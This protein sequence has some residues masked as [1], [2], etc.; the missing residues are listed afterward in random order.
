MF[1]GLRWIIIFNIYSI[2]CGLTTLTTSHN[3]E[4]LTIVRP[5]CRRDYNRMFS[6][7]DS[8]L[9]DYRPCDLNQAPRFNLIL[10]YCEDLMQDYAS[11]FI[12]PKLRK[13][14]ELIK[15]ANTS[16][17]TS[18]STNTNI[19]VGRCFKN[20]SYHS[21]KIQPNLNIYR[22]DLYGL[23]DLWVNGPNRH[24]E[25]IV[26]Y[27]DDLNQT[28]FYLME[29][30]SVP[31]K[32]DFLTRLDGEIRTKGPFAI[33][34]S[35][36]RGDR[37]D[38]IMPLIETS[39]KRHINGN[40]VYN[41]S[42]GLT[43]LVL[44]EIFSEENHTLNSYPYDYRI[45]QLVY[46][47][48][49]LYSFQLRNNSVWES[50]RGDSTVIGNYAA[51]NLHLD[52][53]G[54]ESIIHGA[55]LFDHFSEP[56]A[57]LVQDWGLEDYLDRFHSQLLLNIHP[58]SEIIYVVPYHK[59]PPKS[60]R[61]VK[62]NSLQNNRM[63][64]IRYEARDRPEYLQDQHQQ[65]Q[66]QQKSP[67]DYLDLCYHQPRTT[68][69]VMSTN[70]YM[71]LASPVYLLAEKTTGRPVINYLPLDSRSCREHSVCRNSL[72][73]AE[74]FAFTSTS[75]FNQTNRFVQNM[76]MIY[77]VSYLGSLNSPYSNS[78][79]KGFCNQWSK[80]FQVTNTGTNTATSTMTP[81]ITPSPKPSPSL[82]STLDRCVGQLSFSASVYLA[83]L[84]QINVS[85]LYYFSD[86]LARGNRESVV[87]VIQ[88]R[89][90]DPCLDHQAQTINQGDGHHH[91]RSRGRSG[92]VAETVAEII[93][94]VERQSEGYTS[95]MIH[96]LNIFNDPDECNR[97][98]YCWWRPKFNRCVQI[99]DQIDL[100][101]RTASSHQ[102]HHPPPHSTY[103]L[104]NQTT[105]HLQE[106]R[107][108][109]RSA[110]TLEQNL[111]DTDSNQ[112]NDDGD[113]D[114]V[115]L[116]QASETGRYPFTV[117]VDPCPSIERKECPPT[118]PWSITCTALLPSIV[119]GL[120][121]LGL[122]G[123]IGM[124]FLIKSAW[125]LGV[126]TSLH[127]FLN[128]P[129]FG[130]R[131]I[132]APPIHLNTMMTTYIPEI[133][134]VE[135]HEFHLPMMFTESAGHV[136]PGHGQFTIVPTMMPPP[137]YH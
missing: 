137:G 90:P 113:E 37:W 54:D 117:P 86:I 60:R 73:Y 128:T 96:C 9:N 62:I 19:Q 75:T 108:H 104:K 77:N 53:L 87:P 12:L 16:T 72:K 89:E 2:S 127:N 66:Q 88:S 39:L 8:W 118:T 57:L 24:F 91:R 129:I 15:S 10:S 34:G 69:L 44:S 84:S 40:A 98:P 63:I 134:P 47:S 112:I 38:M 20:I 116:R 78:Q 14:I 4:I 106:L 130:S 124:L 123:L 93:H 59:L 5:F 85:H 122:A 79:S 115:S 131:F 74:A 64:T 83:Y 101:G 48:D 17:N 119:G 133:I 103:L 95:E 132:E 32:P 125:G 41:L 99:F 135:Q 110:I 31:L 111:S 26:K 105:R 100:R 11:Q 67:S 94:S 42:H 97:V 43:R 76:G 61:H 29:A 25:A 102:R 126:L 1:G 50:Y 114:G 33:L 120:L 35:T 3:D 70:T 58:Y 82:T 7:F 46:T 13:T 28:L 107:R 80:F 55:T 45:S 52:F 68:K 21:A 65:Q 36:Y 121:L 30:D 56:I 51:T 18:T 49:L 109:Y 6:S 136:V 71:N 92:V 23:N 81:T 22:P 27:L